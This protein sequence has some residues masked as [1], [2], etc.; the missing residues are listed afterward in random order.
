[1]KVGFTGTQQHLSTAQFD[2][3]AAVLTELTEMTE[4]HHGDCCGGDLT[5][6]VIIQESFPDVEIHIHPPE[7]ENKRAFCVS[8]F[9]YEHKPYLERNRDIVDACDVLIACPKTLKEELRSGT[10]ATVRYARKVGKP[11]AI[12]WNNGKYDYEN[13]STRQSGTSEKDEGEAS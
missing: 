11:V 9:V 10:W 5:F 8:N 4:A 13:Q 1:M 3:L 7:I 6:H 2:L 12:L